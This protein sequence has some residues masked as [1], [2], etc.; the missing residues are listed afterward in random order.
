MSLGLVGALSVISEVIKEPYNLAFILLLFV[1]ALLLSQLKFATLMLYLIANIYSL[2]KFKILDS[3]LIIERLDTITIEFMY[4]VDMKNLFLTDENLVN[5]KVQ[6]FS[7]MNN[8]VTN[9][10]HN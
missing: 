5:Y 3:S 8:N 4:E 1:R 7:E 9:K 2:F 10:M 6:S